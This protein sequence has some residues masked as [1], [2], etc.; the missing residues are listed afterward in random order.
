MRPTTVGYAVKPLTVRQTIRI[1]LLAFT[2]GWLFLEAP[3]IWW[4]EIQF[5]LTILLATAWT[6]STTWRVAADGL[7]TGIGFAVP[8]M[9]AVGWLFRWAGVEVAE[10]AA[11]WMF[12]PVIEEVVKLLPVLL[13][14]RIHS[15]RLRPFN[16]SDWLIAGCAVGAGFALIENVELIVNNSGGSVLRDMARQYGP[17]IGGFY[18]IPGAW[19]IVG[20][21]GHA[22]ATGIAAAGIGLSLALK[23]RGPAPRVTPLALLRQVPAPWWAAA[24]VCFGW[25]VAEHTLANLTVHTESAAGQILGNGRLTPWL[26]LPLFALVIA[27][28]VAHR[29]RTLANSSIL[30]TRFALIRAAWTG[31]NVAVRQTK[32][33]IAR[34]FLNQVREVNLVAWV[35]FDKRLN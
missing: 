25:V 35:T 3:S 7:G 24:A 9:I 22:G 12:V 10:S 23:R 5:V 19:G 20:F 30:R 32:A 27:I 6:R 17:H 18:P 2:L 21:I 34:V 15:K 16:L 31:T 4:R 28:D 14:A 13:L 11:G 33:G 1:G 29:R 8:L 26:A